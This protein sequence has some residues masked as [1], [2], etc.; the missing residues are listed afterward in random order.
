MGHPKKPRKK[1]RKPGHPYQKDRIIE[2]LHLVGKYGLRNKRELWKMQTRMKDI[3]ARARRL[4]AMSEEERNKQLDLM[5]KAWS[6][7]GI[8]TEESEIDDIL[9]LNVEAF[10]ERRLQTIVYKKG[11]ARTPH[12]ARQMIVHGHIAINGRVVNVPSYLV[13][14]DEEDLVDYAPRSPFADPKHPVREEL[15]GT[16]AG[17]EE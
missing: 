2:E 4:L 17:S 1:Y 11:L 7:Y 9:S 6:K 16:P 10:L 8:L 5:R 3:I 15:S 13:K 12:Q 14:L